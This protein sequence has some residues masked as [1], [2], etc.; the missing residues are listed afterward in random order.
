[1]NPLHFAE[2]DSA[3]RDGL[4]SWTEWHRH[5][6]RQKG[7]SAAAIDEHSEQQLHSGLDRSAKEE[8][9]KDKALWTDAARTDSFSLTLDEFLSF[10]HPEASAVNLLSLVD[11]LLRQFDNNMDDLLT[12]DEFSQLNLESDDGGGGGGEER[13]S[14]YVITKTVF[15]RKEEFRRIIDVNK[16]GQANRSELLAYIDPRHPRHALEEAGM[17]FEQADKNDDK[18]LSLEEVLAMGRLFIASKMIRTAES[19]HEE[20]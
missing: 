9:M 4:V 11:D 16:D 8:M 3:P 1:M 13:W 2:I 19:I 5:F 14:K 7:M 17:L 15:D 6:L 10:R 12:I 18:K 20:F